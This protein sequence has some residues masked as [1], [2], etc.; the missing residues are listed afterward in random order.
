MD[1]KYYHVTEK[2][3][4]LDLECLADR[5]GEEDAIEEFCQRW[6]CDNAAFAADQVCKVYL[7]ATLSEAMDHQEDFGG[8]IL[9]IDGEYIDTMEDWAEGRCVICTMDSVPAEAITKL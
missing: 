1:Q 2:W 4:G 9:E 3:D 8:E 6:D 7:Y 5:L